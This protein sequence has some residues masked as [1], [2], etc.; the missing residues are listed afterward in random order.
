VK[1][2]A[3]FVLIL[4]LSAAAAY[5]GWRGPNVWSDWDI[6]CFL[7]PPFAAAAFKAVVSWRHNPYWVSVKISLVVTLFAVVTLG[8]QALLVAWIAAAATSRLSSQPLVRAIMG[9]GLLLAGFA[10]VWVGKTFK[11]LAESRGTIASVDNGGPAASGALPEHGANELKPGAVAF[12]RSYA[13]DG[14]DK[15]ELT[16]Q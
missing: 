3:W 13:Q 8:G 2:S 10:L 16:M 15:D 14:S 11:Q 9:V 6:W 1:K 5:G 12:A 4:Y 7:I